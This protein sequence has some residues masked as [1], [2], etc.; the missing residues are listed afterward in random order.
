VSKLKIL[1]VVGILQLH[2]HFFQLH[3]VTM[4]IKF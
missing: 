4:F 2:L 3:T 1:Q